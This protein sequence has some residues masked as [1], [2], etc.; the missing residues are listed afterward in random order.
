MKYAPGSFSKNFAWHGTGLRKLHNAINLGFNNTLAPVSRDRWRKDS[1]IG[2]AALELIPV[3][4]FLHN[5]RGRVSVDELVFQAVTHPHSLRFDRLGLFAFHLNRVGGPPNGIERPAMWANEFVRE[6]L[7]QNDAWRSSELRDQVLDTFIEG[8]MNA[9]EDVRI[10]CRNNYRHLFELCGYAPTRL[11]IMN[12][13]QE[14]W[15]SSALFLAWD[16]MT[17]DGDRPSRSKL[18]EYLSAEELHK[19]V[20]VSSNYLLDNARQLADLYLEVG[21]LDRFKDVTLP[22]TTP[23][24]PEES[25]REWI[26]Q[27]ESDEAVA[28]RQS[29]VQAQVRDRRKAAALKAHYGNACA[30]CGVRLQVGEG[31]FYSEAAH[32]RPLGRPYDGPDKA[33]N[34]LVLCPNHHLQFDRGIVRI[35]KRKGT[36]VV[37]STVGGDPLNGREVVL[38]HSLDDECVRWHHDWFTPRRNG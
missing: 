23:E 14:D 34:M 26:Y 10:K 22:V 4:F 6:K 8:R 31:R 11:P 1:Q 12:A 37:V 38:K 28:R 27:E 30:I 20:G 15:L 3:N 13:G 19:L 9:Q 25:E 29:Q 35:R 36:Y 32:I 24:I 21:L 33:S 2:D 16:R 7:W 18:V 5:V 17:L